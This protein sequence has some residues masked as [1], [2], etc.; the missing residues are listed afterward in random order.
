MQIPV[1]FVQFENE[2]YPYIPGY[3]SFWFATHYRIYIIDN[4]QTKVI[5]YSVRI[6]LDRYGISYSELEEEKAELLDDFKALVRS[7]Y[8]EELGDIPG[9]E[10]AVNEYMDK[11]T[12]GKE[13][14]TGN[15]DGINV[16]SPKS[17]GVDCVGFV[18]RAASY[19]PDVYSL[20]DISVLEWND[21]NGGPR[22]YIVLFE[23]KN[24]NRFDQSFSLWKISRKIEG[25]YN[26]VTKLTNYPNLEKV[27]PGDIV[28]Y[29]DNGGYHVM[30]VQ[31][32]T[33]LSG[34]ERRTEIANIKL[35]ESNWPSVRNDKNVSQYSDPEWKIGR[36]QSK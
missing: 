6:S 9:L 12:T 21:A 30:M 20:H 5:S 15:K 1:P 7:Y 23:D 3:S 34:D 31:S 19:Q 2:Y 22:R 24:R 29:F 8:R 35:I 14:T 4:N 18:Q 13:N 16:V 25:E 17:A 36:L 27:I 26:S 33:Y 10:D 32:I 11:V 28:Y